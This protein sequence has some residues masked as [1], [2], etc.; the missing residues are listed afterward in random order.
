[1]HHAT[2]QSSSGTLHITC[3]GNRC[4]QSSSSD[5]TTALRFFTIWPAALP[6]L[7]SSSSTKLDATPSD[8]PSSDSSTLSAASGSPTLPSSLPLAAPS[9]PSSSS[10]SALPRFVGSSFLAG[11][12]ALFFLECVFGFDAFL[13]SPPP[14]SSVPLPPASSSSYATRSMYTCKLWVGHGINLLAMQSNWAQCLNITGEHEHIQAG[15]KP[16]PPPQ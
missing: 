15:V 14:S 10:S 2:R 11:G 13:P 3:G 7:S 4:F 5:S 16:R 8:T 12:A 1:M 9:L 6:S